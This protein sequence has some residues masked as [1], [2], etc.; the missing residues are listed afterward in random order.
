MNYPNGVKHKSINNAI[1]YDNRG[2]QLE[3]DINI[4]N[5]YYITNE[6]AF[7]YKKPTP[8]QVTDVE[9]KNGS[10]IIKK[11]FFKEASTTDYNGLYKGKY[12]DFEAKETRNITS[13]PLKNIG[14]HQINHIR[15]IKDNGG[16]S[17][18]IV[19]FTRLDKTFL[20]KGSDFINFIDNNKRMSIPFD[21]FNK[22]AY[23]LELSYQ[24][25]LDYLKVIEDVFGGFNE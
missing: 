25:R 16:I 8:I 10:I 21:Y 5:Q 3:E 17:F 22:K 24:P 2:M 11:A 13:F 4:T 19:R 9:Y 14:Q 1:K 18:L 15:N 12:I 6:I 20:I 7:I 23:L